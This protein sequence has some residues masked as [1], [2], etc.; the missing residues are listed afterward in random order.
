MLIMFTGCFDRR[1]VDDLAYVIAIGLDKGKTNFLKMT[2]Q[3][4]VPLAVGSGNEGGGGN[5]NKSVIL[6][7]IETP[8]IFSGLNMAN[9]YLSKEINLSHAKVVVFSEEL[10]R[11]GIQK[12]INAL[13][14]FREVRGNTYIVVSR[15]SAEEYLRSI[16][17]LLE[18]NPAKFFEMNLSSYRYTSFTAGSKLLDF[19]LQQTS[20]GSQPVVTLAST[21]KFE[22]SDE[23]NL[24]GSTYKEKDRSIPLEGDFMAGNIPRVGDLKSEIMGI[25]VFD[26]A[27]MVGELDGGEVTYYLIVNGSFDNFYFTFADPLHE[28]DYI[29]VSIYT[30]RPPLSKMNMVE[31]K[32]VIDLDIKLEGD[33]ISIQSGENYEDINK[34]PILEK[35]VEEFMKKEMERFLYKTSREFKSDICGFGKQMKKKFIDWNEWEKFNWLSKY[36]DAE[37]NVNIDFKVRRPGLIVRSTPVYTS[38][39]KVAPK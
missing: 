31:D 34:L 4:A 3:I 32:P 13:K 30:G 20:S 35:T 22:S 19:Q 26:G 38:E 6:T 2:L 37:F 29:L 11:E 9:N 12:Y 1:E 5:G 17:P 25:A 36:K 24:E 21:G 23:F 33:I 7:T 39:G 27:K 18:V 15:G 14:R 28:G 10:A 16:K 8:S